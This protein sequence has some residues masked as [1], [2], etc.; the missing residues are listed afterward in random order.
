MKKNKALVIGLVDASKNPRPKRMLSLLHSLGYEC[1][2]AGF[3]PQQNLT[4]D[5]LHIIATPKTDIWS[6]IYRKILVALHLMIP[7][8]RIKKQLDQSRWQ[9]EATR[10]SLRRHKFDIIIVEDL[11]LLP[12]IFDTKEP[13]TKVIFDAREFYP[14][15]YE[16]NLWWRLIERPQRVNLCQH[17][18]PLCDKVLTVSDG[19]RQA[20]KDQFA[21]DA[22]RVRSLPMYY[23][24]TPHPTAQ[25]IRMVHHGIANKNRKIENMI[26][27]FDHLDERYTLDFYLS[28]KDS[29]IHSL[30]ER[31]KKHKNITFYDQVPYEKIIPTLCQYDIG[32]ILFEPTTFNLRHCLPNKLFEYIQARLAIVSGPLPDISYIL[33]EHKC[34]FLSENFTPR[35]MADCLNALNSEDIN[36]AKQ[37]SHIAANELCFENE[38]VYIIDMLNNL[39]PFPTI[40][41]DIL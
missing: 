8:Y 31:A 37:N 41:R 25:V 35:S 12:F 24:A 16:H 6:R 3:P 32:L 40:H 9:M 7:I 18:L 5:A 23:A 30:K 1:H 10:Q 13:S 17:Y 34:G 4:I 15:Q 26:D 29:Y 28:G 21:I 2:F 20:Y 11:H 36:L 19:L 22:V 38:K 39:M 33:N 14:R 27:I